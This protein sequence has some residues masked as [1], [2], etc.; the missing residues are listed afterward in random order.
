MN[1]IRGESNLGKNRESK[2]FD[3]ILVSRD[4]FNTFNFPC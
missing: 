3:Q 1:A 4:Q 2:K